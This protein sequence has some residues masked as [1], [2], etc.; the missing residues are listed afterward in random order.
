MHTYADLVEHFHT[1]QALMEEYIQNADLTA[2]YQS[3]KKRG[4]LAHIVVIAMGVL[5]FVALAWIVLMLFGTSVR[6]TETI[7]IYQ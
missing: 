2:D 4:R 6:V 7:T 3:A 1:P 5:L